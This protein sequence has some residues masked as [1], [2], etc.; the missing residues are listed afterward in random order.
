MSC[1]CKFRFF[2]CKKLL[3][4]HVY[5]HVLHWV[6]HWLRDRD[7]VIAII[8]LCAILAVGS[9]AG[10]GMPSLHVVVADKLFSW[11]F[12]AMK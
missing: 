6:R 2:F 3:G 11:S 1:A 7:S 4:V 8:P 9:A 12:Y 5:T 10:V